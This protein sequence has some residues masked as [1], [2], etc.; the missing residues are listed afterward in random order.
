MTE[1]NYN[2]GRTEAKYKI[3][4]QSGQSGS[5]VPKVRL[6]KP[7]FHNALAHIKSI[8]CESKRRSDA[9]V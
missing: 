1:P 4:S 3:F 6:T 7:R 8:I 9:N 5:I 2:T